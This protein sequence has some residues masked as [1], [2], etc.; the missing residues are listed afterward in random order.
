MLNPPPFPRGPFAS[1]VDAAALTARRAPS[2]LD[3]Q[4]N[5]H[6]ASLIDPR[7][8]TPSSYGPPPAPALHATSPRVPQQV[9]AHGDLTL[10]CQ[11]TATGGG[12]INMLQLRAF[13]LAPG[14]LKLGRSGPCTSQPPVP[15][16]A[17]DHRNIA[18]VNPGC[19]RPARAPLHA[20][21]PLPLCSVPRVAGAGGQ[22]P[23]PAGPPV[24][25]PRSGASTPSPKP[26]PPALQCVPEAQ[27]ASR[28]RIAAHQ[29][30][31]PRRPRVGSKCMCL[32]AQNTCVK[33]SRRLGVAAPPH[34]SA[35]WHNTAAKAP[36]RGAAFQH[37]CRVG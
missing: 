20:A 25:P 27:L 36:R 7:A 4:M 9:P 5:K 1:E 26:R 33:S 16:G 24:P 19:R 8:A 12:H 37:S 21:K 3:R 6:L 11:G 10:P 17:L 18:P 14:A 23:R 15:A 35:V 31:R 22:L 2:S 13:C 29:S 34:Q 32:L 30:A 28:I